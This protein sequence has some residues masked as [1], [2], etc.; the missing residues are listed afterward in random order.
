VQSDAQRI[1]EIYRHSGRYDVRV[2]PEIIEQPNNRVDLVFTIQEGAKTGIKSI[3]FVGNVAYS[4]YRLR[5]IIKTRESNLLSFLGGADV[6]DP[7]RVEAD[8]DLIRR[9]YLK[10]GYADVQVVAALTEYDPER[11]GFLVTFKIEEGQQ[12]RVGSVQFNSSIATLDG[13]T[14]SNF[15][16]VY[17]GSVY[18]AEALEKSVEEMQIEASR[19]GYAFAIVRPRGD[20]NFDAHTVSIVFGIDEGPRTYIERINIRG[21]TR[22]RDYVIR[23]EFDVSEGDAYNRALVDRAERRLK[24]LD[25]FKTVKITTEPGSSSDRVVLIVDL[26]EKSTGDFSVSGGYS[27]TDGALGEVSISERNFLGRGLFAKAA[28]QYGQYARGASLSFVDPYLLDYRV[29]GGLDIFYR[30]QLPNNYISYGTK[31]LG[32]S[33]RLGFALREDLTLQLRYSLY[34]QKISLPGYL[35]NCNNTFNN[36]NLP[37]NPSPA[38]VAANGAMGAVDPS[39]I[40]LF[41]YSD[42]EASLP[43]RKELASGKTLTSSVGYSLNYNTLDNNK[44]PTDGL[45]VDFRQDFAGVGGDVSYLKSTIDGKYYTPLVADIVGLVH[46]Q[47]GI[48]NKVGSDLRMLDQFQMGPNLVRGFAPNGI[49]PRDINPFGTQDALGGTKYWGASFELQMPFWFLPKEVGLKGAVYA[50]AGGLYDYKGPTTWAATGELTTPQNS[51]C[52][53]PSLPGAFPISAGTCTGLVY[54]NSNVVRTSVGVGLIWA[55]PFGPLRFD[56]AVPLTKGQ[57]DRVQQFKFGGGTSF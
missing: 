49:G 1:V 54:D 14:L 51:N 28:V 53:K 23:R 42:G 41:C 24:N 29:A 2:T 34:E 9:F 4:S 40:G 45:L 8:R 55:S 37:F 25:Y 36:P 21:N 27:T 18:N 22:T 7:D 17:V 26:E 50:D 33:P 31:T 3:E 16:H 57:F 52:I 39:G 46:L 48:L 15:S 6:Y 32:F 38:F 35:A 43:I 20:R 47:G 44:N 13:N 19:R 12:Y 10:H 56:Y 5:D 30:E 11:K